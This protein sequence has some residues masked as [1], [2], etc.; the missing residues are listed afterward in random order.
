[1]SCGDVD[2][3]E[4]EEVSEPESKIECILGKHMEKFT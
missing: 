3:G 1:M 4:G 2:I